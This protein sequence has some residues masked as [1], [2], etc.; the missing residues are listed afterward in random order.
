MTVKATSERGSA[1]VT[2]ILITMVLLSVTVAAISFVDTQSRESGRERKREATFQLTEGVMNTQIFL[3]SR[4]WP[5]TVATKYPICTPATQNDPR[6]PDTTLLTKS[7]KGPDY[8]RGI[9]WTSELHDNT[10]PAAE[11]YYDDA[12]VRQQPSWD[13]NGDGYLWVRAEGTLPDA[14]TRAI[15][16]LIRAEQLATNFPRHAVIAGSINITQNGNHSYIWTSSTDQNG[17]ANG[18]GRVLVR[19]SPPSAAGCAREGKDIQISPATVESDPSQPNA[20]GSETI[21]RLRESARA[22][23]T[24][25][26]AG[27]CAPTLTGEVIFMENP[28]GC[29][30]G[31]QGTVYN[32]KAKPGVIIVGTGTFYLA[33]G[34]VHALVYHVNGSDGVNA[35]NA[36]NV[37]AVITKAN[38]AIVGQV[39]IDG[40][41][42]LEVGNNNGGP[43]LPGNIVY[44]A[45]AANSLKA[46]GTAGIVQNSFREIQAPGGGY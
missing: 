19:C 14:R 11:N 9:N 33:H 7:F 35:P 21:E 24:Y 4:D 1:L 20:L 30:F 2:A 42:K 46:F 10:V 32:S 8:S 5:G 45:N 3:L 43:G 38:S 36:A 26:A 40:N 37:S 13:V 12:F 39:I 15:V 28:T 17:Q 23:G 22:N 25:Y 29:Q 34:T 27:Q 16:A 44:D 6:C 18:N 41:G 31:V